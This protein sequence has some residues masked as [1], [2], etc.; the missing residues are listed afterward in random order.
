L[1]HSPFLTNQFNIAA[2]GAFQSAADSVKASSR[3]PELCLLSAP[4]LN[5]WEDSVQRRALLIDDEPAVCEFIE[6]ILCSSGM[7]V[8]CST[9][10]S[11]AMVCVEKEKFSLILT[12]LRM[13]APDGIDL[14]RQIRAGGINQMTPII[15]LSDDQSTS[16]VSQGFKVGVSFFLY[17]PIDKARL[18]KLVSAI[19]GA[20]EHERR[21]FQR[22]A[23]QSKIKISFDQGELIGETEDVSLGGMLVKV[24][25]TLPLHS[26]VRVSLYLSAE[27]KPI[28]GA[29]AIARLMGENRMG[30]H[31]RHMTF[32][33][34][35]RLQ[36]LLLPMIPE[37]AGQSF[38][39]H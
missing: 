19:Q 5:N 7:D 28:E 24:P 29:G 22:I 11:D 33:D 20:V 1:G 34:S 26:S 16:V 35:D 38:A 27:E 2:S 25:H 15:L 18:M 8:L 39:R 36:D 13:P 21:R 32:A 23:L 3:G 4:C 12:D 17:K 9:K 10:S 14:A 30:I 37:A 31:L 6:G